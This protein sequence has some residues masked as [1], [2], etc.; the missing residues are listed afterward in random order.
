[1]ITAGGAPPS[2]PAFFRSWIGPKASLQP[3]PVRRA[4]GL[5]GL[6]FSILPAWDSAQE[7]YLFFSLGTR[8]G[9]EGA[10]RH[11][12]LHFWDTYLETSGDR[13]ILS[14][15]APFFTWR[16]LVLASPIWYPH[17]DAK[18]RQDLL[19]FAETLLAGATFDPEK[20]NE[21]IA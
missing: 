16:C 14:C 9:L 2:W 1:M 20:V 21:L 18:V 8:G 10:L 19:S 11:I 15:V 13:E 7:R 5:F 4:E 12:W 3:E 17:L 6:E